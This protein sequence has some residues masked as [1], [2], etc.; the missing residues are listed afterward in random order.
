MPTKKRVKRRYHKGESG[1]SWAAAPKGWHW[2]NTVK[3]AKKKKR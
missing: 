3:E 2:S 1:Y